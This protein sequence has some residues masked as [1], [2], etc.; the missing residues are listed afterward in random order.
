MKIATATGLAVLGLG[1]T[2]A[3]CGSAS[4]EASDATAPP[5]TVA[6]ERPTAPVDDVFEVDGV[7]FHLHCDG[8]GDTTVLLIAG[9]GSGGDEGWSTVRPALVEQARV[10]T[11]DRP[12]TGTSDKPAAT[13]TFETQADDLHAVLD[14]AGEPGPYIVVGHSFGGAQA[15]TFTSQHPDEVAGLMLI[16]ASPA[17]WPATACT[18]ASWKALCDVFHD[19]SLD[20]ERLDVFPAFGAVAAISS[21]GDVP[22]TVMPRAHYTYPGLAQDVLTR[23]DAAWAEGADRWAALSSASTVVPVDDTGH[24]IQLEQPGLVIDEV[25]KLLARAAEAGGDRSGSM[26]P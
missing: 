18:V 15:V 14:A 21:L 12:G 9:W 17:T 10:C 11:Y 6:A 8:Q 16:D 1:V 5:T 19:P 13:Q 2:L 20:G 4:S 25:E 24:L 26:G 22:M 23:L 7:G 3:G